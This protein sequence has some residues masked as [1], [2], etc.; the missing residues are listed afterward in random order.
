MLTPNLTTN[1]SFQ[2]SFISSRMLLE[3]ELNAYPESGNADSGVCYGGVLTRG[4][5][6]NQMSRVCT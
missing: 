5:T 2:S 1:R 3:L 4:C 6:L